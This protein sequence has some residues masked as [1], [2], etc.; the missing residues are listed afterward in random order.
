MSLYHEHNTKSTGRRQGGVRQN[1]LEGYSYEDDGRY[2][3]TDRWCW[4]GTSSGSGTG[5][6]S[7]GSIN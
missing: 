3:K 1:L 4:S 7:G 6:G 2:R 5:S